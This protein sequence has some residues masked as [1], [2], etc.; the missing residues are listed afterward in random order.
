MLPYIL[1]FAKANQEVEALDAKKKMNEILLKILKHVAH[2]VLS[3]AAKCAPVLPL[4]HHPL[5]P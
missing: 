1:S 3:P 5:S 4:S 2:D